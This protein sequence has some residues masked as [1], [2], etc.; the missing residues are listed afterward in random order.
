M[1]TLGTPA[2]MGEPCMGGRGMAMPCC[3]LRVEMPSKQ[4]EC[5]AATAAAAAVAA[6]VATI[7]S[8]A[9]VLF[10]PTGWLNSGTWPWLA[11]SLR[12]SLVS[13]LAAPETRSG[14]AYHGMPADM[15]ALGVTLYSF[16]FGDVPF[17]VGGWMGAP[18]AAARVR[19]P[20]AS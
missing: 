4:R 5:Y 12:P 2:F 6:A 14:D 20:A 13:I 9:P 16:L 18:P 19:P 17:K 10:I 3:A 7:T 15:W 8:I 1:K 11:P